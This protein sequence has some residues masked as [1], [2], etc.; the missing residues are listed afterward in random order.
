MLEMK[1]KRAKTEF[2]LIKMITQWNLFNDYNKIIRQDIGEEREREKERGSIF[3]QKSKG[4]E[5][6]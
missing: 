6:E 1:L 3:L 2:G 5:G 4:M